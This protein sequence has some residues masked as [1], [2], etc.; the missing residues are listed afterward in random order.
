[1]D[2]PYLRPA[3]PGGRAKSAFEFRRSSTQITPGN[4]RLYVRR[5]P[6]VHADRFRPFCQ[7]LSS[8]F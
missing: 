2:S 7:K 6:E 3:R 4:L 5:E 1:M 8:K